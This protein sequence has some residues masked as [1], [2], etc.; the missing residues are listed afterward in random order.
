MYA[1]EINGQRA[2]LAGGVWSSSSP[3]LAGLLT[4][5]A[6]FEAQPTHEPD[7]D[8]WLVDLAVRLGG[9]VVISRPAPPPDDPP[10]EDG[11]VRIY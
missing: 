6:A 11:R 3:I 10:D 8:A 9:A 7:R 1:I 5:L 4:D 2:E